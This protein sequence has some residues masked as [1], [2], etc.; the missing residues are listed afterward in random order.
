MSDDISH[1]FKENNPNVTYN[2]L[3]YKALTKIEN[4]VITI[5]ARI[6]KF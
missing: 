4:Q 1:R 3:I 6:I 2:E 5:S